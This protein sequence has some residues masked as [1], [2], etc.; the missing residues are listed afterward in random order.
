MQNK[1]N[2]QKA[3][4]KL[5]FYSTKDYENQGRLRNSKNKPNQT[6]FVV[7]LP[8]P[9]VV[10]LSNLFQTQRL[11]IHRVKSKFLNFYAPEIV[12]QAGKTR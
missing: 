7:S 8:N 6:Q 9:P 10:S 12:W 5:S 11:L 1:P 4:M 2:F 3:K